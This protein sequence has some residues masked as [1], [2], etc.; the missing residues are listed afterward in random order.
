MVENHQYRYKFPRPMVTVDAAVF[1]IKYHKPYILLIQRGSAPFKDCWALP[2]GFV[3][4]NEDLP[5]AAARE[6]TEET[7]LKNIKLCQLATFGTPG[8]DPRGRNITVVYAG[9][10][11]DETEVKGASD[12]KAAR[13]FDIDKLPENLAFDHNEVI[14][15]AKEWFLDRQKTPK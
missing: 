13:W 5:D 10:A 1:A 2:G 9:V 8:R 11:T 15:K 4:M 7:G 14:Q 12:A 6:L 3:D